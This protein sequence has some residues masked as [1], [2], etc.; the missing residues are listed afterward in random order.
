MVKFQFQKKKTTKKICSSYLN[1]ILWQFCTNNRIY[2]KST[3][4]H[5]AIVH[6][7]E[8]LT[9]NLRAFFFFF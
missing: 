8:Y 7:S 5:K 3:G 2:A 9:C 6:C 4:L 1:K